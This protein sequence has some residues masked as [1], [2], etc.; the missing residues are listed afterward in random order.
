MMMRIALALALVVAPL[1]LADGQCSQVPQ[2]SG[3]DQSPSDS[4]RWGL[5]TNIESSFVSWSHWCKAGGINVWPSGPTDQ[6]KKCLKYGRTT[7]YRGPIYGSSPNH[8]AACNK[9]L[10]GDDDAAMVAVS[11]KYLKSHQGGWAG[12]KGACDMCMCVRLSGGD[13]GFNPGLQTEPLSKHIG[14][15][16]KAKVRARAAGCVR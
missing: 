16:F 3:V 4:S 12:D 9:I 11:T 5:C 7:I 6:A 1:T 10:K 8:K 14:L 2:V 13:K 15:T